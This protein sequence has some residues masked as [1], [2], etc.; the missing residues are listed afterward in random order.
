MTGRQFDPEVV[1]A[2]ER[3]VAAEQDEIAG[4]LAKASA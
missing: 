1:A 4:L 3:H 2:L